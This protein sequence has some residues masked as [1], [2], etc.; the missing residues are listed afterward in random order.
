MSNILQLPIELLAHIS[1]FLPAHSVCQLEAT[2]RGFKENLEEAR[3]WRKKAEQF[4]A[5]NNYSFVRAMLEHVRVNKL[6]DGSVFKVIVAT[7]MTVKQLVMEVEGEF[8]FLS[9]SSNKS[10]EIAGFIFQLSKIRFGRFKDYLKTV[11][12]FQSFRLAQVEAWSDKILPVDD[13]RKLNYKILFGDIFDCDVID[14]N[15]TAKYLREEGSARLFRTECPV[16]MAA[17]ICRFLIVNKG[18]WMG[19]NDDDSDS[20]VITTDDV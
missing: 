14:V 15:K 7:T 11:K 4:V 9:A 20:D 13:Y 8:S 2:S 3:A 1:S 10:L 5:A 18:P 17:Y 6:K 19:E 12:I 16:N